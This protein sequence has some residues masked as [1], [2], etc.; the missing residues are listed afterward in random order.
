MANNTMKSLLD[1]AKSSG[2]VVVEAWGDSTCMYDGYGHGA[3]A[4]KAIAD[5]T[6]C[7]GMLFPIN[8]Q[9]G[10]SGN[11]INIGMLMSRR[12]G[13]GS[14]QHGV[15]RATDGSG[16]AGYPIAEMTRGYGFSPSVA[17]GWTSPLPAYLGET[18]LNGAI[19]A[20]DLSVTVTDGSVLSL[21]ANSEVVIDSEVLR[22][23]SR[24]GNVLTI[25][26]RGQWNGTNGFGPAA[27]HL[28]G[29]SVYGG[30]NAGSTLAWS[31]ETSHPL[32]P[33][34]ALVGSLFYFTL[35]SSAV[36]TSNF[37][38]AAANYN[39]DINPATGAV[40]PSADAGLAAV[41]V[42]LNAT[43]LAAGTL[44]YES[45]AITAQDRGALTL[46]AFLNAV[47]ANGYG[48]YGPACLMYQGITSA[49]RPCGVIQTMGL[50]Q[51]GKRLSDC[52]VDN[53]T[54]NATAAT[55]E[56]DNA[57]RTK[58]EIAE[59]C[60]DAA[61]GGNGVFG[62]AFVNSWG[63]NETGAATSRSGIPILGRDWTIENTKALSGAINAAVTNID[64]NNVTGL[65]TTGGFILIDSEYISYTTIAGNQLQGCVRGLFGTVAASHSDAAPVYCGYPDYHP[66][67]FAS[68]LMYDYLT[69]RAIWDA[70]GYPSSR[71]WYIWHRPISTA[72]TT[73]FIADGTAYAGG[74]EPQRNYKLDRFVQAVQA[75]VVPACDG[76]VCVDLSLVI[77]GEEAVT[78]EYGTY[79][80]GAYDY[81][82][83]SR[84]GCN[85]AWQRYLSVAAYGSLSGTI[86]PATTRPRLPS[87]ARR[88]W[89]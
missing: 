24:S 43:P 11:D 15:V 56:Y 30:G 61:L 29:A 40:T 75:Y 44:T 12:R 18:T 82:H 69:K 86:T 41:T 58:Y 3:A 88:W 26:V 59:K 17:A 54:Y 35:K 62:Y 67:G 64:L 89:S 46:S 27:S 7:A 36:S 45:R 77:T 19:A 65:K 85:L 25:G 47:S 42:S 21:T 39:Y 71:F 34:H 6:Y 38:A 55:V 84:A 2:R 22:Y 81:I 20:G 13:N 16:S 37:R 80:G 28:N 70:K 48:P 50:S 23:S 5:A 8:Y 4:F 52:F 60:S 73:A 33:N 32:N 79:A 10:A 31:L 78:Y 87:G 14:S 51:G 53:R 72:T 76:F 57:L 68:V 1:F 66:Q 74:N 9:N 63:H 83:P 49:D